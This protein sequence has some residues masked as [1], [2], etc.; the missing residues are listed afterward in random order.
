MEAI[1]VVRSK[2]IKDLVAKEMRADSRKM[3]DF[4]KIIIKTGVIPHAEGSAQVDMGN[5]RVLVGVK[6]VVE[7]PMRDTPEQGN[8]IVS[9]ELLPL[10]SANYE[11]GPPSPESIELARVV[12]RGI[13]SAESIDVEGLFIEEGK[14][15]S[16][17]VDIYV[18]NYGGNL[19]DASSIAAMTA[20]MS[21]KIPKYEEGKVIYNERK[22]RLKISTVIT[23]TT[24]VKIND[25]ILIDPD[26]DEEIAADS[27]LTV[28][29]D[30]EKLRAMQKGLGGSMRLEEIDVMIN[31]SI[32]KSKELKKIMESA[33][34]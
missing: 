25:K 2:Y 19:L 27:R 21:T 32:Q 24:F 31:A 22:D 33:I 15:W 5:T 14:V 9:A 23:S 18:L 16:V 12:D 6:M 10:A 28:V 4:R 20:L 29:T 17:Y 11:T 30:G 7:E 13:R 8:L 26:R 34:G 3:M 1:D